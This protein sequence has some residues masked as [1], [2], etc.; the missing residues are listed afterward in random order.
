M[1]ALIER[2]YNTLVKNPVTGILCA[3]LVLL[4]SSG[5]LS[6][7]NCEDNSYVG[8]VWRATMHGN[9]MHLAINCYSLYTLSK[10]EGIY[11]SFNY[12]ILLAILWLGS[13]YL[14]HLMGILNSKGYFPFPTCSVGISATILG[15]VVFENI[16]K[17]DGIDKTQVRQMLLLLIIP[18]IQN[19]QVSI[20]G[21]MS[22]IVTGSTLASL[23][24]VIM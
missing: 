24:N 20:A 23:Y 3:T 18:F 4:Y 16:V 21:H 2:I 12:S 5:A 13:A 10:L 6:T 1:E 9:L 15:L 7:V 11:G 22:G 17:N 19:P 8:H 14:Q